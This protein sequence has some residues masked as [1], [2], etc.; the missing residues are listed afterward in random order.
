LAIGRATWSAIRLAAQSAIASCDHVEL[1]EEMMRRL[2]SLT[3]EEPCGCADR[4]RIVGRTGASGRL[5]N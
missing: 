2:D 5:E 3:L 4:A 1:R